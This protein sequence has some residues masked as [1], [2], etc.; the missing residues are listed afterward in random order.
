MGERMYGDGEYTYE[1]RGVMNNLTQ[2]LLEGE[3]A[4]DSWAT[5]RDSWTGVIDEEVKRFNGQ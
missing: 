4:V 3:T 1:T 5:L 2:A